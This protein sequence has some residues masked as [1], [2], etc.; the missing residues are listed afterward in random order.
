M[1]RLRK[2]KIVL[3]ADGSLERIPRALRV[4]AKRRCAIAQRRP[5]RSRRSP[6]IQ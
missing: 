5:Q 6:R 3:T 2:P 4:A 1:G